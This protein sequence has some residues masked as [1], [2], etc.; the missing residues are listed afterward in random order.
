MSGPKQGSREER[1][2]AIG[3]SGK[4]TVVYYKAERLDEMGNVFTSPSGASDRLYVVGDEG[5]GYTVKQGPKFEILSKNV[6][7]DG[8]HASPVIVGDVLYL[9]GFKYLYAISEK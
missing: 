8:F 3:T 1:L 4:L 2:K 9:R 5:V 7:E 6:L